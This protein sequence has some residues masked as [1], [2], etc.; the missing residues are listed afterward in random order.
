MKALQKA[1][2]IALMA[3]AVAPAHAQPVSGAQ[4][5]PFYAACLASGG[6]PGV[7]PEGERGTVTLFSGGAPARLVTL[8]ISPAADPGLRVALTAHH[9][10]TTLPYVTLTTGQSAA[11]AITSLTA[12]PNGRPAE[13]CLRAR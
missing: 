10:N 8:A 9:G 11:F 6:A 4:L 2:A 12:Q 1:A 5:T 7:F 3:A 13:Y